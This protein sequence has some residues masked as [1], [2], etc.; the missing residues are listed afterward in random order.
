MLTAA[1]LAAQNVVRYL[2]G[3]P[4]RGVVRRSDYVT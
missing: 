4:P 2:T 3:E 1:R